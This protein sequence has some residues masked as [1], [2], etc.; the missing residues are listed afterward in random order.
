MLKIWLINKWD[1]GKL[2]Q[3]DCCQVWLL[4]HQQA[5]VKIHNK[6]EDEGSMANH[7]KQPIKDNSTN[8]SKS[9]TT[10]HSININQ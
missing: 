1:L 8:I 9:N 4:K 5:Q 2:Y 3:E 6:C 10:A 7:H